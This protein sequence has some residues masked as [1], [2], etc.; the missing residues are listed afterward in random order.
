MLFLPHGPTLGEIVFRV[1][2]G[3]VQIFHI[4]LAVLADRT[5]HSC[6]RRSHSGIC[7]HRT[8][9]RVRVYRGGR[10]VWVHRVWVHRAAMMSPMSPGRSGRSGDCED[11][12]T[13]EDGFIHAQLLS[14]RKQRQWRILK[15]RHIW[16]RCIA[17]IAGRFDAGSTRKTRS[18]Q[19]RSKSDRTI[20]IHERW[21]H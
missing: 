21:A 2:P 19:D 11:G 10:R 14:T 8:G 18:P 4:H 3:V 16:G 6:R 13:N 1:I 5:G 15:T 12:K 9:M 17:E 20:S 7:V